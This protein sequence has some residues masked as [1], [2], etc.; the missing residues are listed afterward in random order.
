MPNQY[1]HQLHGL[2]AIAALGVLI[3][4]WGALFDIHS[5]LHE[6]GGI[7]SVWWWISFFIGFGWLGVM[8]FFVL[9]GTVLCAPI[10]NG[11]GLSTKHFYLRRIMR[12]YPAVWLQILI[13][14]VASHWL[15]GL[16]GWQWDGRLLAN[17]FLWV[18]LPPW[19]IQP[20]NGV[21]WTLPIELGFY[22]FFPFI[23]YLFRSLGSVGLLI[24]IASICL[25]WR[26]CVL[27]YIETENYAPYH[28][29]LDALPSSL[30]YFCIG[31][32]V[33][34]AGI[35][36]KNT[37]L[38]VLFVTLALFVGLLLFLNSVV[39]FY[40]SGH[41]LLLVWPLLSAP[42]IGALI[43]ALKAPLKGFEWLGSRLF[44]FSGDISFGIYLWHFPVMLLVQ[45][46]FYNPDD[47][48]LINIQWLILLSAVTVFIAWLSFKY[49]EAPI[50]RRGRNYFSKGE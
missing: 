5:Q 43:Y 8:F 32:V 25:L 19:Y 29:Y 1:M 26:W 49:V 23:L 42:I 7:Y 6:Y 13:F 11:E 4:H 35:L 2:R 10:V 41:W 12:I 9:S 21:W 17:F 47:G 20:L 27:Q 15:S 31:M 3:F 36:G 38:G 33:A 24:L 39:D 34:H 40:W 22:L 28:F 18:Q 46:N 37:A 14:I 30:L 45:R 44:R 48:L 50:I 16:P